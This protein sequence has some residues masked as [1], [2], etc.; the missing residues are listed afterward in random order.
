MNKK[1]L[2][3]VAAIALALLIP[4]AVMAQSPGGLSYTSGVQVVNLDSSTATIG[5]TYYNQ[6]GSVAA[7]A[8]DTI[9][10]NSS[11]TYF[12]IQAP[13]GFNGSLVVSSDKPITAIA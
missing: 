3:L 12:P 6:D 11:K 4:G 1:L 8:A 9:A 13:T 7:T 5:L 10:G 2:I